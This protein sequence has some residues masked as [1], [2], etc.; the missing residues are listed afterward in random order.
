MRHLTATEGIS[1]REAEV[2]AWLA[3]GADDRTIAQQLR[4]SHRTVRAHIS[5][6]FVKLQAANRT[7]LA[8]LG[9]LAHLRDCTECRDGLAFC[10]SERRGGRVT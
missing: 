8:L 1:S 6:L 2:L 9:L 4:V 10:Y 7:E 5:A 3:S